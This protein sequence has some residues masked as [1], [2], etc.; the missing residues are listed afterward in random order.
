MA[1]ASRTLEAH[2]QNYGAIELEALGVVWAVCHFRHYI[3]G[4]GYDVFTDHEAFKALLNTPHL[5]GKLARWGLTLRELDL[6]IHYRPGPKNSNADALSR[7]P[8]SGGSE[9]EVR[10]VASLQTEVVPA[11]GGDRA[12]ALRQSQDPTFASIISFLQNKTLPTEEKAA[13]RLLVE[14][15]LFTLINDILYRV[16]PDGTLRL[17]PPAADRYALFLEAHAGKFGGHLRDH[18]VY[19]QLCCHYWWQGMRGEVV[20]WCRGCDVC[21]S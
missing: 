6:H 12:L 4:H 5:S 20:S 18:K 17:I 3:Y 16:L 7:Y 9:E 13:K 19:S 14:Q 1:Y 2:E 11:E 10:P 8:I 21:A 15:S